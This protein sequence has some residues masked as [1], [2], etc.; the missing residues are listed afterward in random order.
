LRRTAFVAVQ[1]GQVF[2]RQRH[3]ARRVEIFTPNNKISHRYAVRNDNLLFTNYYVFAVPTRFVCLITHAALSNGLI[4]LEEKMAGAGAPG[5]LP[6]ICR[7]SPGLV[8]QDS[9]I[10]RW[11][12]LILVTPAKAG[13]MRCLFLLNGLGFTSCMLEFQILYLFRVRIA[14]FCA[15]HT[16]K[17][18]HLYGKQESG[19]VLVSKSPGVFSGALLQR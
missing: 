8:G 10:P 5:G 3:R 14:L 19:L 1:V 16:P 17:Y 9:S 12:T 11:R 7:F 4:S 2:E 13:A 18:G 6:L 15:A